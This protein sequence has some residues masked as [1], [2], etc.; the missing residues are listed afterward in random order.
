MRNTVKFQPVGKFE[1]EETAW[2]KDII[3]KWNV[4][5]KMDVEKVRR[6]WIGHTLFRTAPRSE[7]VS[8][9]VIIVLLVQQ[10]AVS[11]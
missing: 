4:V 1:R 11:S 7:F 5:I 8:T 6:E 3:K 9:L 2:Q 10:Q